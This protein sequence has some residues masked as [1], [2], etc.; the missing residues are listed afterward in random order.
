MKIFTVRFVPS[1]PCFLRLRSKYSPPYTSQTPS[2]FALP[3]GWDRG[4]K[5]VNGE[6]TVKLHVIWLT[7]RRQSSSRGYDD[8]PYP[9]PCPS[10]SHIDN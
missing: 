1:S 5:L 9:Y 10:P 8:G 6:Q 7:L 3:V 2:L 4:I